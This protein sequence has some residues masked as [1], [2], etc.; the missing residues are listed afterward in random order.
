[1]KIDGI[2]GSFVVKDHEKWSDINSF[3]LSVSANN[4]AFV[5]SP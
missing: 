5:Q 2:V 4:Q 3:A 1:M